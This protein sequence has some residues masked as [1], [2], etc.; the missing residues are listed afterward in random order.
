MAARKGENEPRAAGA[1]DGL[2]SGT[3]WREVDCFLEP[4]NGFNSTR[5]LSKHQCLLTPWCLNCSNHVPKQQTMSTPL[6][7]A[8]LLN[9][10]A[11]VPILIYVQGIK[12]N[13]METSIFKKM[14][15]EITFVEVLI[16][17]PAFRRIALSTPWV[18]PCPRWRDYPTRIQP[19]CF[20]HT[21][22]YT[23]VRPHLTSCLILALTI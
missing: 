1:E 11:H 5:C 14:M 19:N 23:R 8:Y 20:V 16:V 2:S 15:Y 17:S 4:S 6:I 3:G 18:Y 9:I 10:F 7:R 22:I 12:Q 13:E 21:H